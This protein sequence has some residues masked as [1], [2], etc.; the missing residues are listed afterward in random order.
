MQLTK[1]F[2]DNI[3]ALISRDEIGS[4]IQLLHDLLKDSPVLEETLLHSARYADVMKQIRLGTIDY[5]QATIT[6]N[7]IRYALLDLVREIDAHKS[8]PK[9]R[10]EVEQYFNKQ[11][12]EYDLFFLDIQQYQHNQVSTSSTPLIGKTV[13]FL[14][15]K[16]VKKL[17]AQK[18]VKTHFAIHKVK[19]NAEIQQKLKALN[20]MTNGYVLKGTFLCMASMEQIRSVSQNANTSKFF[21]FEDKQGLRTAIT[22]FVSGNL[23]DQFEQILTHIKRNIYLIRNIDT[24]TEDY[25][26]PEKVFTELLANAFVHR[27]YESNVLTDIKVEIYPDRMEIS[28][29]GQFADTIDL[30]NIIDNNKSFIINPEIVQVFF[31]NNYVETAA[32]GIKRSQEALL[33][34]GLPLATFEQ[35]NGYV[36]VIIDKTKKQ[37]IP[38][39]PILDR[40]YKLI[41]GKDIAAYF[42]LMETQTDNQMLSTLQ[43]EFI[44]GAVDDLF[45]SR[46]K[47][48][49]ASIFK[50][51]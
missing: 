35:K 30:A 33:S 15:K 43:Q 44:A 42:A 46:L 2:L 13:E 45:F 5:E 1:Y 27:S 17:F 38:T 21:V 23:I 22:E 47:V 6:K 7:Q 10:V 12:S 16:A 14:D 28:N 49:T 48:F 18:R 4:A 25:E 40:A 36:K 41:E 37:Q 31:L 29:P 20:L 32:K 19:N 51:R 24:R 3:N 26:I 9:I 34:Y 39:Q 8:L 50:K 11:K